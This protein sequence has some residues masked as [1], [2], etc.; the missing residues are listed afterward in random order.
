[1]KELMQLFA[2][3]KINPRV[4]EVFPFEQYED[5]LAALSSRRAKGKV[6]LKVSD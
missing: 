4:S 2:D 5:A 6:V 1:L 3:G